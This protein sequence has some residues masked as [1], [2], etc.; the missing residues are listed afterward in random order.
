VIEVVVATGIVTVQDGGRRGHMHEGVPEGGALV[1]E[2]LARANAAAGN[3]DL[4]AALEVQG[5]LTITVRDAVVV[6]ADDGVPH[7]LA[8]G[9]TWTLACGAARVRYASV[10]GGIDVPI[11]LGGR[12]TLL[13]AGLGGHH[14]R[15]LRRGDVLRV[16]GAANLH[17][18]LPRVPALD[19]AIR[20]IPGPDVD[21]F[22]SMAM[23][24]LLASDYRVSMR[25]DRVG[26]R[27]EGPRLA[28]IDDDTAVSAPMVRGAIQVPAS[29]EPIVLG[30]DHPTTGGYPVLA[31]VVRADLGALAA[32]PVRALVRFVKGPR[33]GQSA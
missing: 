32:R 18:D 20:V 8:S 1:P 12:G 19:R 14:G 17:G 31:T 11:V 27:L 10:R 29:G 22:D 25:S 15:P 24:V 26:I 5:L 28:R 30:P 13:V 4:D 23:E 3:A 6:A 16:G 9:D 7:H 2:L 33:S 21:R